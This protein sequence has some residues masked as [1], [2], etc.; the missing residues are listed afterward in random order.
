M[1]ARR[2]SVLKIV[3]PGLD[4]A[5]GAAIGGMGLDWATVPSDVGACADSAAEWA[6]LG[7]VFASEPVRFREGDRAALAMY[8]VA[9]AIVRLAGVELLAA[10]VLVA[11]RSRSDGSRKVRSPAMATWTAASAQLRYWA[12]ELGLTPDARVRQG[13]V[14][15][16]EVDDGNPFD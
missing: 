10:G 16:P 5:A 11:G 8:C 2:D 6:R 3:D 7:G 1:P 12:R 15:K 13:I 14:D 9:F 4:A